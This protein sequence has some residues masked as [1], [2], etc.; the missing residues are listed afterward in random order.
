MRGG[1]MNKET[2]QEYSRIQMNIDL[3]EDEIASLQDRLTSTTKRLS[4]MPQNK[5]KDVLEE[6]AAKKLDLQERLSKQL[7]DAYSQR[8]KIESTIESLSEQE[9]MVM[10]LRYIDK[11]SW[12]SI[13]FKLN[14]SERQIYYI[15][16]RAL[17]KIDIL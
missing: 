9:K 6:L 16:E 17:K 4:S 8:I 10:R 11:L 12:V 2:L 15:H 1:A 3:L 13:S 7:I 5:K 14:Y